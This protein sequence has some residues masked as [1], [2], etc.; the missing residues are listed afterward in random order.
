MKTPSRGN[1]YFFFSYPS[2]LLPFSTLCPKE[3]EGRA[4]NGFYLGSLKV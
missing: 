2:L 3:K 1:D 4:G